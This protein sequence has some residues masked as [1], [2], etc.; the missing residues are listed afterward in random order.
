MALFLLF[1]VVAAAIV[2]IVKT[3]GSVMA[4]SNPD[5]PRDMAE[6]QRLIA[7]GQLISAIKLHR[8]LTGLGLKES[9]DAVE[10]MARGPLPSVAPSAAPNPDADARIRMLLHAGKPV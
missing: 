2:F 4:A 9:K 1:F 7:S 8:E 3:R 10:A 5:G 6:V